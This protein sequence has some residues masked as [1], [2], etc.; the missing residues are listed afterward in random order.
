MKKVAAVVVTYNRKEL[1]LECITALLGQNYERLDIVLI[2]NASTDGTREFIEPFLSNEHIHY[3][4]TGNNLGGAGG[5]NYGIKKAYEYGYDYFW[6]MDDDS[7]ANKN[8]L[9]ALM[10]AAT[11]LKD[12][13]GFLCSNVRWLDGT[14]CKM[15]IPKIRS[16]W[17][18]K[19]DLVKNGIMSVEVATFVGYLVQKRTVSEIGLPIKEFFIWSDDT[20][21]SLRLAKDRPCYC[22]LDSIIV[23]KMKTNTSTDIVTDNSD[24]IARY[25]YSYRNKMYNARYEHKLSKYM[26]QLIRDTIHVICKSKHKLKKLYY[27]YKGFIKGCFFNPQIEYI[28]NLN[29]LDK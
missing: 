25:Y 22:I 16:D 7:I 19:A 26:T 24:R 6:L 8:A 13:F 15:N 23:H 29:T 20:N 11:D 21:Y 17:L 4:N 9:K 14:P 3:Y 27:M 2:D 5:F 12:E 18:E 28:F 10:D 1:L